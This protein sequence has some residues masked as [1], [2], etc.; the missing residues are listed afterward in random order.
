M[1]GGGVCGGGRSGC[2]RC[3]VGFGG[4]LEGAVG[5][6]EEGV[7]GGDAGLGGAWGVSWVG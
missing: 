7:A 5:W 1:L 2:L 6:G 3:G 4:A